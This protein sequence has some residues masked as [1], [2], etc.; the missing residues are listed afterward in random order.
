MRRNFP[1][2]PAAVAFGRSSLSPSPVVMSFP[3][4]GY[5]AGHWSF[6]APVAVKIK[7]YSSFLCVRAWVGVCMHVHKILCVWV[8]VGG[9]CVC[10]CLHVCVYVSVC[11]CV[12]VSVCACVCVCVC[13]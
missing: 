2:P 6:L 4:A 10:L 8:C 12:Y 9:G 1:V 5:A 11:V 13:V 7:E 3:A